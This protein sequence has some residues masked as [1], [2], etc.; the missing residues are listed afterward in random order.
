MCEASLTP[1]SSHSV[2]L[3][4]CSGHTTR[5]EVRVWVQKVH[6][7]LPGYDWLSAFNRVRCTIF[8]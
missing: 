5:E 3:N 4:K 2:E 8:Q 6:V 1:R 7:A